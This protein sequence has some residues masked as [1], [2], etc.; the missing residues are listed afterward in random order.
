MSKSTGK[1]LSLFLALAV[2][3]TVLPGLA[4]P[5]A[6]EGTKHFNLFYAEIIDGPYYLVY[7]PGEDVEPGEGV[8]T[9][10][11]GGYEHTVKLEGVW[12]Y[13][14]TIT[15]DFF[16]ADGCEDY[17]LSLGASFAYGDPITFTA[18]GQSR[19][20]KVD[21]DGTT[22][23]LKVVL[24]DPPPDEKP[25]FDKLGVAVGGKTY[26]AEQKP[27]AITPFSLS[28]ADFVMEIDFKGEVTE[29]EL[30]ESTWDW[31]LQPGLT[32]FDMNGNSLVSGSKVADSVENWMPIFL[33]VGSGDVL[34]YEAT[35]KYSI[36]PKNFK[37]SETG[38][39]D[40]FWACASA[41]E[42]DYE[43]EYEYDYEYNCQDAWIEY[44]GSAPGGVHSATILFPYQSPDIDGELSL[45]FSCSG[46][47]KITEVR[48]GHGETGTDITSQMKSY[49]YK[50]TFGPEPLPFT[51]KLENI[52]TGKTVTVKV[53]VEAATEP[54][55]EV[56]FLPEYI[57]GY[58]DY[59]VL[60]TDD[61]LVRDGDHFTVLIEEG[62][63]GLLR[64]SDLLL[65]L[66]FSTP[67]G[68]TTTVDG[69]VDNPVMS[70]D[71]IDFSGGTVKFTVTSADGSDS[72]DY[73]VT[74]AK[75]PASGP[76]LF[77]SGWGAARGTVL[78]IDEE[79][80]Y[81]SHLYYDIFYAN[82]GDE[83]LTG[84]RA[85]ITSGGEFF[86]FDSYWSI[87]DG[88]TLRAFSGLPDWA[89]Y[90]LNDGR[91][92]ENIGKLR[93]VPKATTPTGEYDV[94]VVI[95]ADGGQ[96]YEIELHIDNR[97]PPGTFHTITAS[98][99]EGGS[100]NP[101]GSVT[102]KDGG[103]Q[104]FAI[105]P[106]DGYKIK[107]IVVDGVS[108][109]PASSYIFSGVTANHSISAVFAQ[110]DGPAAYTITASAG[111]G[112]SIDPSGS[113]TVKNGGSQK[114]TITPDSGYKIKDV[115]VDGVSQGPVSSYTFS[116]VDANHSIS[117]SFVPEGTTLYTITATA[118][119]GGSIAPAGS[120]T[121]EEGGSQAFA[122]T[123]NQ[124]YRIGSVLV[125]E[126]DIGPVSSH[127]FSGVAANHSIH[128]S[129]VSG[130]GADPD[131][132][133]NS[134]S[135]SD[136]GSSGGRS[137]TDYTAPSNAS[138]NVTVNQ[139]N[140][141]AALAAAAAKASGAGTAT[142]NM[143]NVGNMTLA[144]LKAMA[145]AA[146]MPVRFQADSMSEDG[147]SVD[148]RITLDPAGS[149][150]DLNLSA[151]TTN[152]AAKAAK[153]TFENWFNNKVQ[154]ISCA[155]QGSFG[156]PVEIAAKFDLT[157]MDTKNLRFYSYDKTTNTYREIPNTAYWIDSNGYL[158]FTTELAGDIIISDGVLERK[159]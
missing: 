49:N 148:V 45:W 55:N 99:G 9:E 14:V 21:N 69:D 126:T 27:A 72:K 3:F 120:V 140:S 42:Y 97:I 107:E 46:D 82:I 64:Q 74:V 77:V 48:E 78:Y 47:W 28:P 61:G 145:N 109:G 104:A 11:S 88:S 20:L 108:Q 159:Q 65:W 66:F 139:A 150:K 158:H 122:I 41:D 71:P 16:W 135:G 116:G 35:T 26:W 142:V 87:R 29:E 136:S 114:F 128:V 110:D 103:N 81:E 100:I 155:Q 129:F 44:D 5:V 1:I 24:D 18:P 101:S 157:G 156:Q 23:T 63:T 147:G 70:G 105:T 4:L 141:A 83:R 51:V 31:V 96:R 54:G 30:A 146:G 10:V 113:V 53:A 7:Y 25:V 13:P 60:D 52:D 84:L 90:Q 154:A 43:Y 85:S 76:R 119:E 144:A 102:V 94:T 115:V 121:V 56:Y 39:L 68:S 12:E 8:W 89:K 152:A 57:S 75:A 134:Y 40:G 80:E 67:D 17:S 58:S 73:Y 33:M 130:G 95:E 36:S 149:T 124:N 151:S 127:T 32:V 143:K 133:N 2:A 15:A 112:G 117:A 79:D 132:N 50:V 91:F 34:N 19:T 131:P 106:D 125:D 59:Q 38:E 37:E 62:E 118:G 123:A 111:E 92:M 86:E 153:S 98:A 22:Y 93:V 138:S 137:G 6:A